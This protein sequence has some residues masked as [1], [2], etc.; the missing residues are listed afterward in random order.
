M[1][2]LLGFLPILGLILFGIFGALRSAPQGM[3]YPVSPALTWES[4]RIAFSEAPDS[5]NLIDSAHKMIIMASRTTGN[6]FVYTVLNAKSGTPLQDFVLQCKG[7]GSEISPISADYL[8]QGLLKSGWTTIAAK[9]LPESIRVLL[10]GSFSAFFSLAKL[11]PAPIL[12]LQLDATPIQQWM[13]TV[14]D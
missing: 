9:D 11:M 2:K 3:I 10:G 5:F 1:K 14:Q 8:K 12:M 13:T 4:L 6:N 7:C